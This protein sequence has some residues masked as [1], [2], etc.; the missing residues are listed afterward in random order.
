MISP[1]F[2]ELSFAFCVCSPQPDHNI[3]IVNAEHRLCKLARASRKTAHTAEHVNEFHVFFGV[4][5]AIYFSNLSAVVK[6][7]ACSQNLTVCSAFFS[8]QP[9]RISQVCVAFSLVCILCF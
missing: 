9:R 6:Y 4:Y 7:S 3:I 1:K 8:I 2:C 5:T